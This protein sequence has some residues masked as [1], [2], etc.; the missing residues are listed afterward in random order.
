MAELIDAWMQLPNQ[1]FL[2]D[3]M[4]DSLRRRPTAWKT[5]ARGHARHYTR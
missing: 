4:F 2:L 3:P 5:L 1:A